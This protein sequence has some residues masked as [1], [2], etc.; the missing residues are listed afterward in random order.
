MYP[1][2]F[3]IM[4]K[5]PSNC[6]LLTLH[7]QVWEGLP[8]YWW[9]EMEGQPSNVVSLHMLGCREGVCYHL[10]KMKFSQLPAQLFFFFFLHCPCRCFA[11]PLCNLSMLYFRLSTKIFPG[12]DE[13]KAT[14]LC[15]VGCSRLAIV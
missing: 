12:L 11:V 6:S 3:Q 2:S 5:V 8:H 1:G 13:D 14:F 15:G 4:L 9:V 7:L 10:E